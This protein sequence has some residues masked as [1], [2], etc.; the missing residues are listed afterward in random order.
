MQPSPDS[1]LQ[2][3]R[4]VAGLAVGLAIFV[5]AS[6]LASK[7]TVVAQELWIGA[8]TAD[9]TPDRPVGLSGQRHVRISKRP[10][11]PISVSALALESRRGD[12]VLDQAVSVSCD[13]VAIREGI[14]ESVREKVRPRLP[15]LDVTRLFL[16]ATHTHTA[17]VMLEGRYN[18][19]ETG[20]MQPAE[21]A[22]WMT[23]RIADAVVQAWQQRARGKVGWGQGQAVVAQNRRVVF[24][25]GRSV[26]YGKT[27][28]PDFHGLEGFE[29][30]NLDALFFWDDEDVLL[31]TVIN[32]PCPSQEVGGSSSIHADFWHPVRDMLRERHGSDLQIIPWAG[33]SGDMTSRLMFGQRADQRMRKLRG[34]TRLE[35]LARRIVQGWEE[36]YEAAALDK[37]EDVVMRHTVRDIQLP[38]RQVTEAEASAA[39][40]EAAKYADQPA[41]AWNYGW[42]NR[43]VQR[44][45]SQQAGDPGSYTMELHAL[46][47]GDVAIATNAFELFTDYGVRIKARSP[48]VQ[49][50][51]VQLAGP[52]SY[53]PTERAVAGGGYSA[54]AQSS[55]VGPQ[56]GQVLVDQTLD[57]IN[58]LWDKP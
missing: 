58:T 26:M 48:A 57:A 30:H 53:L 25:D 7:N 34:L 39:R 12:A 5:F 2:T 54:V 35:E 36:A 8:A 22:D 28:A 47:L 37:R 42:H 38:H 43:V 18:L 33:A 9:I 20:I 16:N 55:V 44:Y 6:A 51:I 46:R 40:Q 19:P 14:L 17:P 3:L 24:A 21:F 31:A 13:L 52:G 10:E 50:L 29:D 23:D 45:D 49:T 1:S 41:E 11:T 56:G 15:D 4:A 27:N 32:V